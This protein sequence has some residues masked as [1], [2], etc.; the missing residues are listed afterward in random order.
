MCAYVCIC[1]HEQPS[2]KQHRHDSQS[3]SSSPPFSCV[4]HRHKKRNTQKLHEV[5]IKRDCE[6]IAVCY[7]SARLRFIRVKRSRY[8]AWPDEITHKP[9]DWLCANIALN[10]PFSLYYS[11][12]FTRV[13]FFKIQ[14]FLLTGSA[15]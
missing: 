12:V 2:R 13:F 8:V 4:S 7:I 14:F 1:S 3:Q 11:L 6:R 10:I 5:H 9:F 15:Q